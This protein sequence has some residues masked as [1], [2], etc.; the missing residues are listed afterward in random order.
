MKL[1]EMIKLFIGM[2]VSIPI[3]LTGILCIILDF[4]Y[5]Y[6]VLESIARGNELAE[7]YLCRFFICAVAGGVCFAVTTIMASIMSDGDE[8]TKET[9]MEDKDE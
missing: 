1:S 9:I 4:V 3:A 2:I 6:K 5:G 8:E 7:T